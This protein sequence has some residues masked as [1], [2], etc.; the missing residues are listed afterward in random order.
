M[1][2]SAFSMVSGIN[3]AHKS[4]RL[5]SLQEDYQMQAFCLGCKKKII[6]SEKNM[7]KNVHCLI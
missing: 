2:S 7:V 5:W 3:W 1:F 6:Y 4:S